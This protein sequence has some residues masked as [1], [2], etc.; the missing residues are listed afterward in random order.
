MESA[1]PV[2]LFL[3]F[4]FGSTLL[5]LVCGIKAKEEECGSVPLVAQEALRVQ[6]FFAELGPVVS[7]DRPVAVDDGLVERFEQFVRS[8][9]AAAGQFV[10]EPSVERL[11][12][13]AGD[14]GAPHIPLVENV[15][16]YLRRE[17]SLVA[18][19]ISEP[20]VDRLYGRCLPQAA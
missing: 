8:E 5:I 15:E 20:S 18:Q 10:T 4:L 16:R 13:A 14:A 7:A 19:F 11:Y 9:R 6:H 17:L 3:A 1:L 12:D 2:L